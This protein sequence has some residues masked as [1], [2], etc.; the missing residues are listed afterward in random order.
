MAG[1]DSRKGMSTVTSCRVMSTG[2]GRTN[3]QI[4][5]NWYI[6]DGREHQD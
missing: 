5:L 1:G 6:T 3:K 4:N 2:R